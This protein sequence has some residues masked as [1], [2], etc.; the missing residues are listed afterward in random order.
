MAT[1]KELSYIK[2]TPEEIRELVRWAM[3]TGGSKDIIRPPQLRSDVNFLKHK[4]EKRNILLDLITND[5]HIKL[6]NEKDEFYLMMVTPDQ[7]EAYLAL[8]AY[9]TLPTVAEVKEDG[10]AFTK[11]QVLADLQ[12]LHLMLDRLPVSY[13]ERLQIHK[14]MAIVGDSVRR[15]TIDANALISLDTNEQAY[16]Y[17]YIRSLI[18][19]GKSIGVFASS[20]R[21]LR[22]PPKQPKPPRQPTDEEIA[23][24]KLQKQK[25]ALAPF[26]EQLQAFDDKRKE[27]EAET[28]AET[29]QNKLALDQQIEAAEKQLVETA[30]T[31]AQERGIS[32][33]D[34]PDSLAKN[35]QKDQKPSSLD[36]TSRQ[37]SIKV[38]SKKRISNG[39]VFRGEFKIRDKKENKP[40]KFRLIQP[41][42]KEFLKI[43]RITGRIYS[44]PITAPGV[45][46]VALVV[47]NGKGDKA[48]T[49]FSYT[50]KPPLN[51]SLQDQTPEEQELSRSRKA[52]QV[53][54]QTQG[55]SQAQVLD[56]ASSQTQDQS[57]SQTQDRTQTVHEKILKREREIVDAIASG[58]P[59][60][61]LRLSSLPMGPNYTRELIKLGK[62]KLKIAAV[63][64]VDEKKYSML[65]SKLARKLKF[66]QRVNTLKRKKKKDEKMIK[67][68]ALEGIKATVKAVVEVTK[69]GVEITKKAVGTVKRVPIVKQ[70]IRSLV[71]SKTANWTK[72]K[73]NAFMSTRTGSKLAEV[74][75]SAKL[76]DIKSGL[77]RFRDWAGDTRVI[78]VLRG[79]KNIAINTVKFGGKALRTTRQVAKVGG[80]ITKALPSG[81]FI[82]LATASLVGFSPIAFAAGATVGVT[83]Q[84]IKNFLGAKDLNKLRPLRR[85]QRIHGY[86]Q[87][88]D[89]SGTLTSKNMRHLGNLLKKNFGRN[90]IYSPFAKSVK[91]LSAGAQL[92]SLLALIAPFVGVSPILALGAGVAVGGGIRLLLDTQVGQAKFNALMSQTP[93]WVGKLARLPTTAFLNQVMSTLWLGGELKKLKEKYNGNINAYLQGEFVTGVGGLNAANLFF[94][95]LGAYGYIQTSLS[96]TKGLVGT[97]I[98]NLF[99]GL[100]KGQSLLGGATTIGA[101]VV[102]SIAGFALAN[103]LGVGVGMGAMI[104]AAIGA[105]VGTLAGSAISVAIA[106][107]GVGLALVPVIV[108]GATA[109]FQTIGQAIG[110]F[111][112]N[113][114]ER[115]TGGLYSFVGG[116]TSMIR[117]F[118]LFTTNFNAENIILLSLTLISLLS[119]AT[120][121][122]EESGANKCIENDTEC[123]GGGASSSQF[124]ELNLENYSVKLISNKEND[125][126]WTYKEIRNIVSAL[127]SLEISLKN[128]INNKPTFIMISERATY[129]EDDFAIISFP[130][131]TILNPELLI[132]EFNDVVNKIANDNDINAAQMLIQSD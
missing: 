84:S 57:K 91:S 109:I 80:H 19:H 63:K 72:V 13:N 41:P 68:L 24:A 33:D 51:A 16:S 93:G 50:V 55:Q 6:L 62:D 106:P 59:Q 111:F 9:R 25:Q 3:P 87:F 125:G 110:S 17:N 79:G 44:D 121:A 122:S 104:G 27:E 47:E 35:T 1:A 85:I 45:Y 49:H 119:L 95:G 101:T 76:V 8:T 113:T 92:G 22:T 12:D 42:G 20:Q 65:R 88:M 40:W 74:Y 66:V 52:T 108:G 78:R 61:L 54:P 43:N 69:K 21:I 118:Q 129:V 75:D 29:E 102:G 128:E 70:G 132:I 126:E 71:N 97:N 77:I 5:P 117:L 23:E 15:G 26:E 98:A 131:E 107:S 83:L 89:E 34:I 123:S 124:Y 7:Q 46:G 120:K 48:R 114:L 58:R 56:Q 14:A 36:Q 67:F 130:L 18:A 10:F 116:I 11:G 94:A 64:F 103:A 37:L 2:V 99:S 39:K 96:L 86:G 60:D 90:N 81:V 115:I 30:R 31:R 28:E 53:Q 127:D 105:T 4:N 32:P 73:V 38:L 112:D 82:G 100:S